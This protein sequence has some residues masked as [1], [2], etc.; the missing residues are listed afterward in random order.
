MC[1]CLKSLA[2][3]INEHTCQAPAAICCKLSRVI[4]AQRCIQLVANRRAFFEC[5]SFRCT[6][7]YHSV[8]FGCNWTH[9]L[10]KEEDIATGRLVA[11]QTVSS[12]R[13]YIGWHL[14]DSW[15]SYFLFLKNI[16][17]TVGS[18][19]LDILAHLVPNAML[20]AAMGVSPPKPP[21]L[22]R[23]RMRRK[24]KAPRTHQSMKFLLGMMG[25]SYVFTGCDRYS[26]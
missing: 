2:I 21:V 16:D 19:A 26:N 8:A 11:N 13:T 20:C 17:T 15:S 7:G 6:T 5:L 22:R 25:L 24:P 1:P 18:V 3:H 10:K 23:M 12:Y 14:W 9:D 4:S